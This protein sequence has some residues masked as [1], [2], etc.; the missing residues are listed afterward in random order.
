MN[1][2]WIKEWTIKKALMGV[3]TLT[4]SFSYVMT[5]NIAHQTNTYVREIKDREKDRI[6]IVMLEVDSRGNLI[7]IH[8][9]SVNEADSMLVENDVKDFISVPIYP[10]KT[11]R[12]DAPKKRK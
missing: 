9:L 12:L 10:G 5:I 6:S 4:F 1:S 7:A 11:I 2:N 8:P 3:L